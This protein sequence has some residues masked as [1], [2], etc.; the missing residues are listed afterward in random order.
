MLTFLPGSIRGALSLLLFALNTIVWTVPLVLFHLLKL[1]IP[2]VGWRRFWSR[3]QNQMGT[4]WISFNNWN[5]SVT[6]PVRW[7][8]ELPLELEK[9]KWYLVVANHRSWVD[10]LVLQKVFNRRIPF[11]KFF[12]KKELFWVPFLGL[13]WWALD[14]PFLARSAMANKDLEAIQQAAG[15]FKILPV[16]VMNFVEG[17]RYTNEKHEKQRSP[18]THL[19][20]PKPGGMTFLLSGM[21]EEIDLILD[22]TIAYPGGTPTMWG[23]LC[24]SCGEIR[25]RVKSIPVDG[26][27]VGD[28]GKDKAF[29]RRFTAWQ[30]EWWA[31]KDE[32]L[33]E[34]LG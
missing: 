26:E 2:S 29:R 22:V 15:K 34:L 28:F 27:L 7:D 19:L 1:T 33:Q 23:F 30:R 14:Y 6:N 18:Y 20:K 5:L 32:E 31:E 12:L 8:V 17:T 25:V 3:V 10:I 9:D 21:K 16:S 24:G 11:L 13:A 4:A